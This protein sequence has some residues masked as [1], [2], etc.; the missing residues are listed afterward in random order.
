M[1]LKE[2]TYTT[3]L[4]STNTA[5]KIL[6]LV[7]ERKRVLELGCSVGTQ[8]RVLSQEL[9]CE[10]TGVE[11]NPVAAEKARKYCKAVLVGNLDQLNI[12]ETMPGAKF[13]VVL[14]AD[15]LEHLIDPLKLLRSLKPLLPN[16][17][18]LVVSIPNIA[19]SGLIFELANGSFEYR[20]RG[21]L[22]DTHIRFFTR[23]SLIAMLSDA[24]YV[25]KHLERALAWPT[26]TEFNVQ[27]AKPEDR[28]FID[29]INVHNPEAFT[30]Q[31]LVQ[32]TASDSD[33]KAI[34]K[35]NDEFAAANLQQFLES[36]REI[37]EASR[38]RVAD[39][40]EAFPRANSELQWLRGNRIFRLA[41]AAGGLLKRAVKRNARD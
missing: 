32:A 23:Q 19:H 31:F 40:F 24:G 22:D 11:L 15:V 13:D 10:V 28:V 2:Y 12:A 38:K 17:G 14:C 20:E 27:T 3:S 9:G 4:D 29:Y 7:G 39:H 18:S 33:T 37:I 34:R 25:I 6:R 36:R 21:L 8:S 26:D 35:L 30:Y 5:A 1:R 16:N 41:E